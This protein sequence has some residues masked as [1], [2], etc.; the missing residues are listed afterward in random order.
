MAKN[1]NIKNNS[2]PQVTLATPQR[3]VRILASDLYRRTL[4]EY[5]KQ[6]RVLMALAQFLALKRRNPIEQFGNKDK[7]FTNGDLKGYLHAGLNHDIQ[8]VYTLSGKDPQ[9]IV[10]HGIFSHDQLGTGNPPRQTRQSKAAATFAN[11]RGVQPLERVDEGAS[12]KYP[13]LS[14]LLRL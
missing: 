11:A 9:V 1:K 7:P 13:L 14:E 12:V 4:A 6:P 2:V 3:T 5:S 10:L 8:I